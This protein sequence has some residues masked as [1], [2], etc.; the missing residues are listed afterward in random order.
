MEI[1]TIRN[2]DDETWKNFKVLSTKAGVSM[3]ILL[4]LMVSEFE[5]I[6]KKFWSSFLSGEKLLT[7]EE[8]EDM[9]KISIG[10]RKE[11]GFRE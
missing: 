11:R 6:N 4:K 2:V 5:K 10:L 1:K 7:D 8:A 3:A 9:I